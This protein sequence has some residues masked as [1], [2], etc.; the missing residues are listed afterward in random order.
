MIIFQILNLFNLLFT[1]LLECI[2]LFTIAWW[3]LVTQL[4]LMTALLVP[5]TLLIFLLD[6]SNLISVPLFHL[7]DPLFILISEFI[8][9]LRKTAALFLH[10][11]SEFFYFSLKLINATL[12]FFLKEVTVLLCLALQFIDLTVVLIAKVSKFLILLRFQTILHV[13]KI[14]LELLGLLFHFKP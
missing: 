12:H 1:Q 5:N 6:F 8:G 9:W 13:F 4:S 3:L 10:L 7:S 11:F 2:L 14:D